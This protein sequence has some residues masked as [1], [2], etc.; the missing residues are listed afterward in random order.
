[1]V[2]SFARRLI[3]CVAVNG[4]HRE[5]TLTPEHRIDVVVRPMVSSENPLRANGVIGARRVRRPLAQCR[6]TC[7]R[8]S[9]SNSANSSS[10][11]FTNDSFLLTFQPYK[12]LD[13]LAPFALRPVLATPAA[14][15]SGPC[16]SV[17]Q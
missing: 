13:L 10:S 15:R 1:V 8:S 7:S 6:Q 12:L 11:V 5:P 2:K 14:G 3:R 4:T 16:R 17:A 9:R